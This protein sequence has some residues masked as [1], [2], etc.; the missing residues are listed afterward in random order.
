MSVDKSFQIKVRS[1]KNLVKELE[2]YVQEKRGFEV[3]LGE[4]LRDSNN[5]DENA[6]YQIKKTQ[7]FLDESSTV[8]ND[9]MLRLQKAMHELTTFLEVSEEGLTQDQINSAHAQMEAAQRLY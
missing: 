2:L 3:Q 8:I 7:E 9:T 1:V 4:L 5:N 6:S